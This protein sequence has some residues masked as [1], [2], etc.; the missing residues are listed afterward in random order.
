MKFVFIKLN[1]DQTQKNTSYSTI[2]PF[3]W[4]EDNKYI[5]YPIPLLPESKT[6]K[7]IYRY[8]PFPPYLPK[9]KV[10]K[11]IYYPFSPS[12]P[13]RRQQNIYI[14]GF[15]FTPNERQQYIYTI[16]SPILPRNEDNIIFNLHTQKTNDLFLT[17]FFSLS[18]YWFL[19]AGLSLLIKQ[20]VVVWGVWGTVYN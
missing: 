12:S 2:S 16:L 15:P 20:Y 13:K 7:Y 6:T 18:V 4:D 9:R 8:Y 3:F 5:Y 10:T 19:I 11:Y 14:T 1:F 17:I